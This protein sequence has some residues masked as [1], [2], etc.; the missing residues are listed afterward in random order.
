MSRIINTE[1]FKFA[2]LSDVAKKNAI[3]ARFDFNN[4]QGWWD[5]VYEDAEVVADM[6][7][8]T[9]DQ[10]QGRSSAIYFSG[11]SS[12][13]DGACFEGSYRYA[14]NAA[15]LLASYAP[16]DAHLHAIAK[17]LQEVQRKHFYHLR[18]TTKQRGHYQHSGCM[19]VEVEHNEDRYRDIGEAESEVTRLL[20]MFADWIYGQL[21]DEHD[22]LTSDEVIAESLEAQEVE[23]L[24]NGKPY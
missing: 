6:L 7:G 18:A 19:Q 14:K 4:D 24:A 12:Q 3:A 20:R 23:F 17:Q 8:I 15:K 13:G 21:S 10:K 22:H 16:Q 11:F 9:F 5:A 2:E 1:V